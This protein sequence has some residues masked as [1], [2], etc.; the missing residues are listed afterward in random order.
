MIAMK[1]Q[2]FTSLRDAGLTELIGQ[3]AI[4]VIPTDTQYGLV[5]AYDRPDSVERI[6]AAKRRPPDK[7]V[8]ILAASLDQL[9]EIEGLD[10]NTLL[11][12]ERFWP[13]AVTV[14]VPCKARALAHIHRDMRSVAC[15]VPDNADLRALLEMTG[16]LIAPSANPHSLEPAGT[17]EKA[18]A[19]FGE[20]VDF[21]VKGGDLTGRQ[22]STIITFDEDG[23]VDVIRQGV[24]DIS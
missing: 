17:V 9:L 16:P 4:G 20:T 23:L 2:L 19:Y 18:Q 22:P 14:V 3:G 10:R 21:Y 6:Y 7:P 24:A 1:A 12:A 13:G 5:C 11:M 8:V 15:R